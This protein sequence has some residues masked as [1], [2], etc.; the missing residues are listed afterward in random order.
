MSGY[1]KFGG[2]LKDETRSRD[3]GEYELSTTCLEEIAAGYDWLL[4][5]DGTPLITNFWDQ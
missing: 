3:V 5:D 1:F 4:D 2:K